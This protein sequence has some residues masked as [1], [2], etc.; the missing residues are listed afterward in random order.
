MPNPSEFLY[1]GISQKIRTMR[2]RAGMNLTQAELASQ[3]A[4]SRTT[5]NNIEKGKQ[6]PSLDLIYRIAQ[7]VKCSYLELFPTD[8]EIETAMHSEDSQDKE[9]QIETQILNNKKFTRQL[10]K[11]I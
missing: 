2:Q 6:R 7:S 3:V 1:S 11:K 4:T 5:I 8:R 9:S 10:S